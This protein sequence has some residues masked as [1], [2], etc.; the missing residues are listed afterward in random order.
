MSRVLAIGR[1]T[2]AR[3]YPNPGVG[4]CFRHRRLAVSWYGGIE[5]F[6]RHP[7]IIADADAY[8]KFG[9]AP[10]ATGDDLFLPANTAEYWSVDPKGRVAI[11]D[12]AS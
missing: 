2:Y 5:W 4:L 11:Y 12:G 10:T 1:E 6:E 7:R 9:D 8:L 3:L